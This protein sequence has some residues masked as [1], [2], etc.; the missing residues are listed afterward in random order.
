M[1]NHEDGLDQP[2]P[3]VDSPPE[4]VL[5]MLEPLPASVTTV[6]LTTLPAS[7][8]SYRSE[9]YQE[10]AHAKVQKM[11]IAPPNP[12]INIV[13]PPH[14]LETLEDEE[15]GS[16]AATREA[17]LR[18]EERRDEE[19]ESEVESEEPI[20]EILLEFEVDD[21]ED[22]TPVPEPVPEPLKRKRV[23]PPEPAN[24]RAMAKRTGGAAALPLT[25]R[26]S[27][28]GAVQ[29]TPQVKV[30]TEPVRFS[31][32]QTARRT[33]PVASPIIVSDDEGTPIPRKQDKGKGRARAPPLP[34]PK[35]VARRRS[36]RVKRQ[37]IDCIEVPSVDTSGYQWIG[38]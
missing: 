37:F 36:R 12:E 31:E 38:K 20:E 35:P 32:R 22:A 8:K 24:K 11:C 19:G 27:Q 30:K 23:S 3:R 1:R 26:S 7:G 2:R 14:M 13:H 33:G 5:P 28:R 21:D 25:A 15:S 17:S 9:R 18:P 4:Y 16:L 29:R 6:Q 34:N 10:M